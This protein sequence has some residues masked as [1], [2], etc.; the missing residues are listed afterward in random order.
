MAQR[1]RYDALAQDLS[2]A[3]GQRGPQGIEGVEGPVGPTGPTGPN[4][5]SAATTTTGFAAGTI[6][7]SDGALVSAAVSGVDF[8]VPSAITGTYNIDG[9]AVGTVAT[10]T[11]A[12]GIL[13]GV[14]T[15]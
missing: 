7:K 11:F 2:G 9:A 15:R 14:T 13:T 5:L 12:A 1:T 4:D 6:L 10:L 8:A 3:A